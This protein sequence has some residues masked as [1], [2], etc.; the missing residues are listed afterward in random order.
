MGATGAGAAAAAVA[1][2][3]KASGTLVRVSST[4]FLTIVSRSEEPLVIVA[5]GGVFSTSYQYLTSYKGLAFFTKSSDP[6]P[7]DGS[8]EIITAEK[9]CMPG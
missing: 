3:I 9:I 6:L 4:N 8:A 1:N 5:E 7:L 2:A